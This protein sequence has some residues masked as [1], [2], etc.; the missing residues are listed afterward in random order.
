MLNISASFFRAS[1]C[2]FP[3][4]VSGL[5]G[6][7][8]MMAWVR[9]AAACVAASSEDILGNGRV[10]GKNYVVLETRSLAVLVM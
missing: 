1:A 9:S 10:A 3:S 8:L 6:V 7:G 2:L 5:V 4:V